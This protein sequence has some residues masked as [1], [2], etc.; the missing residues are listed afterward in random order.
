MSTAIK[1]VSLF[2]FLLLMVES[3]T[4]R[5]IQLVFTDKLGEDGT[6]LLRRPHDSEIDYFHMFAW[7]I[8]DL[9]READEKYPLWRS[10]NY[11][12]RS[13]FLLEKAQ[14][15]VD[16]WDEERKSK[17]SGNP[18]LYNGLRNKVQGEL[19]PNHYDYCRQSEGT[20]LLTHLMYDFC[21]KSEGENLLRYMTY[22]LSPEA[23]K[24]HLNLQI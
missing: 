1:F 17:I 4:A 15:F 8:E 13:L 2:F 24:V 11:L 20:N 19:W 6:Y 12:N 23:A 16:L 22:G 5:D 9:Q 21:R 7:E 10:T 3:S 14:D 18:Y